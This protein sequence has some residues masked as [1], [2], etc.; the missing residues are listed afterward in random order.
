MITVPQLI[1]IIVAVLLTGMF[2]IIGY[3]FV[4]ILQEVRQSLRK[5]NHILD[6]ANRITES[7]ADPVVS[8]SGFLS[9]L[10]DGAKIIGMFTGK[11]KAE[12]DED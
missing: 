10:K 1:S 8:L 5:V 3:Q 7:V 11:K 6:D 9:G 4:L 12:R 2:L